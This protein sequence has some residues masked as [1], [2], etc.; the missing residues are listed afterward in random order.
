LV[1]PPLLSS[2]VVLIFP[3]DSAQNCRKAEELGWT[4][5][6]LVEEGEPL[7]EKKPCKYQIRHLE[8]LRTLFP[9]LF[10]TS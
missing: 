3:D 2:K 8:E 1:R 6:H 7:P 9:K 5:T 4:A 10:K